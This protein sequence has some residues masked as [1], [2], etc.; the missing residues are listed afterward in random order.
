MDDFTRREFIRLATL[1][2]GASLFAGCTLLGENPKVPEYIKG[3]PAADPL[4]TLH[5]VENM[6]SVCSLCP[7]NC[8]ISCRV[9]QGTVVKIGGSPYHPA[10]TDR[11]LPFETPLEKALTA[12]GSICA[13]GGSGIQTLYDPFRVARPLKRVGSR[14]SGKWKALSWNDVMREIAQ[15]GDLF[16]EGSVK[17]L[18]NICDDGERFTFLA[19][20]AD[21]GALTFIRRFLAGFPHAVLLR[22]HNARVR[23]IGEQAA[24]SVFG[25]DTGLVDADY[26]RARCLISFGDAP[27]DSGDPLVSIARDISNARTNG[28]CLRWAVIDPRLSTSASK[29][30]LWI[31]IIP[32]TDRKLALAIMKA[33]LERHGDVLQVPRE[34]IE[35]QVSGLSIN[36]CAEQCGISGD[37][38][39]RL[40]N[41]LAEAREWSAVVPGRGI[42]SQ[43]DGLETTK[44][45]LSLNLMVGAVPGTDRGL[46]SGTCR[47]LERAEKRLVHNGPEA[48]EKL[49]DSGF[50]GKAM[51]VWEA[52]P[53][54]DGPSVG[55]EQFKDRQKLPLLIAISTQITETAF[56]ADYILP[57][58]TYLERWDVC[59][60]PP[61]V[62]NPGFGTRRPVVG[63]SDKQNGAYFPILPETRIMEDILIGLGADLGLRG[64]EWDNSVRFKN[65]WNYYKMA[66][67]AA[68]DSMK[69]D[70]LLPQTTSVNPAQVV[71]K[72]GI[73]TTPAS[74][75][76]TQS[77]QSRK[78]KPALPLPVRDSPVASVARNELLL[79]SYTLPFH[80]DARAVVNAWLL[81]VLPDN[82]LMLN[83]DDA[84][85]RGIKQGDK[86]YVE[87]LSGNV[88]LESRALVVPGIRPGVAGLARGF[89]NRQS[90]ATG[91]T[92]DATTLS[93]QTARGAG[94]NTMDFTSAQGVVRV[95][96]TK[97]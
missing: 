81:E 95:K 31:P 62:T 41:Y 71:E 80:R 23:D 78:T 54:Y 67:T 34:M 37:I 52:D 30:D 79:I 93:P 60:S 47:F 25:P 7:G 92:I 42:L 27:L 63:G 2:G 19:G 21:W 49:N 4:E 72:G 13:V 9:A 89:G 66:I 3:A 50:D 69:E 68:V 56:C 74:S 24:N 28:S 65:A 83:S 90:G 84:R 82:R 32:G 55:A 53:V 39:L 46:T 18:K 38:P 26:K 40:A 35:E 45:I 10:T 15:G 91:M 75:R 17:G 97:S 44:L 6:Y 58:T 36:D 96:V 11:P 88:R 22:D 5:G 73:F 8:G 51:F 1:M 29:A 16:N 94:I 59:A 87:D 76:G 61:A 20:R 14:G 12:S 43:A 86:V 70:G 33:L 77:T 48:P 57:D 85:R 64:F